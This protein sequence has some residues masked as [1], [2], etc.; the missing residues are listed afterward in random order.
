MNSINNIAVEAATDGACSGNPGN[1]GW[2]SI[3]IFENGNEIELGGA[4]KHTTNNRMELTAAIK[5]L[6][7]LKNY[8]LKKDFKL[9]T[10]SK[11]VIEGYTNWINNW[12]KNGWKTSTGKSVQNLDLWQKIDSL[13]IDGLYMEFVKGHNGDIYNERVDKIATNYSKGIATKNNKFQKNNENLVKGDIAPKNLQKLFSRLDLVSEFATKG[14]LLNTQ[15]LC[16]LLS[17]NDEKTLGNFKE[18]EWR[19][20]IIKPM[21]D[22]FWK[23][24][25]SNKH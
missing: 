24:I 14:F 19:N 25:E 17:I 21:K 8:K 18:F 12:K 20:W 10:D 22:N 3:I 4:E 23:I 2:G 5:T 9:R 13:R 16:E 7:K 11:Y 15:E 1:G 6:E